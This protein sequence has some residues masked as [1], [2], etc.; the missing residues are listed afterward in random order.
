MI[1]QYKQKAG[2][3]VAVAEDEHL[4]IN[5]FSQHNTLFLTIKYSIMCK[6]LNLMI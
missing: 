2:R 5:P 4:R 1:T 6:I 3:R